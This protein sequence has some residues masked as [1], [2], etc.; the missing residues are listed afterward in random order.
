MA[1]FGGDTVKE[2]N[3]IVQAGFGAVELL[4]RTGILHR[5][6]QRNVELHMGNHG[7]IERG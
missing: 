2:G 7:D 1:K 3:E 4:E 6:Q 5:T